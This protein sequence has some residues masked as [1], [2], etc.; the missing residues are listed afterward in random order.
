MSW[1]KRCLLVALHDSRLPRDSS[2][3]FDV[4]LLLIST[5]ELGRQ[6]IHLAS[7]A[8]ALRAAGHEV[9]TIDTAVEDLGATSLD[10]LDAVAV[11]VPMHTAMRLAIGIASQ[12]RSVRPNLPIAFYGLYAAVGQFLI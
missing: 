12:I 10:S 8:A 1:A 6:P 4:R 5:Y 7:P 2:Y 11:S 3:T 9:S